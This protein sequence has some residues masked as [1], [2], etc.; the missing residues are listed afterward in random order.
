MKIQQLS[1]GY[2]RAEID[3]ATVNYGQRDE[4]V[5]KQRVAAGHIVYDE[6]AFELHVSDR[7]QLIA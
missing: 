6:E 5:L 2:K 3:S 1:F 7:I 4:L